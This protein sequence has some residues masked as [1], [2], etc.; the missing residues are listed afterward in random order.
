[1]NFNDISAVC[2]LF[3]SH[4]KIPSETL[5]ETNTDGFFLFLQKFHEI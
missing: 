3:N 2:F 4:S 1:M 5:F